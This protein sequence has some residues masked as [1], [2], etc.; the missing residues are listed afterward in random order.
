VKANGDVVDEAGVTVPP[1][2]SLIVTLVALPPNVLPLTVTAVSPQVDPDV[3]PS[4]SRGGVAQP[5]LT[6]NSGLVVVQPEEFRAVTVWV[7]FATLLKTMPGCHAPASRRYSI[8]VPVGLV[9]VIT[10]LLKPR[11]QSTVRTGTAGTGKGALT[12]NE[13]EAGETHPAALVTV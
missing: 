8:P 9:T 10:A 4:V 2:L 12:V 3:A 13:A 1:P 6:E 7:P 11:A 5:Q